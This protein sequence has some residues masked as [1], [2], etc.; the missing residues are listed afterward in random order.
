MTKMKAIAQGAIP[1]N[2]LL[3]LEGTTEDGSKAIIRLAN[4]GESADFMSKQDIEDGQEV[5]ITIKGNPVWAAEA[6]GE[7]VVGDM[8]GTSEDGKVVADASGSGYAVQTAAEGDLARFVRGSSGVPGPQGPAGP[9]GDKGDPGDPGPKGD[10]GD[11]GFPTEQEWND[12]VARVEALE[13]AGG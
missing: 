3:V 2:R 11:P 8:V 1:K 4:A 13:N 9:K 5:T 12:L 10:K 7:I 6:G